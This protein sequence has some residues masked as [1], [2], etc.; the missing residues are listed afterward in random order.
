[1][2]QPKRA[3]SNAAAAFCYT[4]LNGLLMQVMCQPLGE[5]KQLTGDDLAGFQTCFH[6][7]S[8]LV[9]ALELLEPSAGD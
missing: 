1:M 7:Q 3:G 8:L 4:V 2:D 6:A 5:S 9:Q